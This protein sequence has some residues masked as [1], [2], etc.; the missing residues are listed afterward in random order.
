MSNTSSGE[1]DGVDSI[2]VRTKPRIH[3]APVPEVPA[4]AEDLLFFAKEVWVASDFA[5]DV[6]ETLLA[7]SGPCRISSLSE[8]VEEGGNVRFEGTAVLILEDLEVFATDETCRTDQFA[9]G[10]RG[11]QCVYSGLRGRNGLR[12]AAALFVCCK[13]GFDCAA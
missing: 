5:Y 4:L 6:T 7:H 2:L 1:K 11:V 10:R 8:T 12:A 13:G 3:G 9:V